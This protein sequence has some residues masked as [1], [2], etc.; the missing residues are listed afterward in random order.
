MKTITILKISFFV[1]LFCIATNSYSQEYNN[2][3]D[4]L[5]VELNKSQSDTIKNNILNEMF[6]IYIKHDWEQAISTSKNG[7]ALFEQNNPTFA[8][9]WNDKLGNLYMEKGLYSM[10]LRAYSNAF[11][12]L[13]NNNINVGSMYLNIAKIYYLQK[14]YDKSISIYKD[15]IK[16]FEK[17]EDSDTKKSQLGIA[18]AY[19]KLGIVYELKGDIEKSKEYFNKALKTRLT[20]NNA[21]AIADSYTSLGYLANVTQEYDSAIYYL[22]KGLDV[23][24]TNENYHYFSD[25]HL[26]RSKAYTKKQKFNKA[27]NDIDTALEFAQKNNKYD[28]SR[29]YFFYAKTDIAKNDYSKFIKNANISLQY[30]D[31]F[32]LVSDK[33]DIL[34]ELIK[35]SIKNNKYKSAFEY[36]TQ[37][38]ELN[39]KIVT[40]KQNQLEKGIDFE[41]QKRQI[42]ELGQTNKSL[43]G[44]N[45]LFQIIILISSLLFIILIVVLIYLRKNRKKALNAL[46]IAEIEKEKAQKAKKELDDS[47][48]IIRSQAALAEILKNLT[49][50]ERTLNVFLQNA[51]DKLLELPWLNV[52]SKGSIFLTN[53]EGNLVMVAEKDLGEV[54]ER[55]AIIKPG[56][57][58]CGKALL[59]KKMQHC[60]HIDHNHEIRFDNMVEHGHYNLPIIMNDEV[61]GVLNIYT[62]HEHKTS[63][64]EIDFLKTVADTIASV[65]N[66][67]KSQTEI[68][69]IKED[70]EEK[71]K[72]IRRYNVQLEQQGSERDSLNQMILAQKKQ[73][74]EKN[75]QVQKQRDEVEQYAKKLEAQSI[76]QEK[77]T[78]QLFA[79]KLEVEQRN[80][81]VEQYSKQLEKQAL[82]QEKLNQQLFAQKLEVEQRNIEVQ[83]YANQL[84]GQSKEQE[85]LNQQLFAQKLEVEQRNF[86]VE[87]YTKQLEDQS[88]EQE[89]LN[90]Q[91]F[92]QKLEVEQRNFEVEQ[93]SKQIEEKAE[94]QEKL[95]Q[96]LFAQKLEV[97]QR[98]FEVEQ[99]T[100][101]LEDQAKEQEKLNQK[102]FAQ[103]LEVE[104]RNMEV[105]QYAEQLE[106]QSKEQEVLNQRLFA[107]SLEVDQKSFEIN[108][109]AKEVENLKEK[110]EGTLKHLNDSINY[111]K[112]IQDSLLPLDSFMNENIPG[113]Y[114]IYYKPKE[115]IGGDFYYANKIG[116]YLILG[117]ADCT[118]HGVPG[119][120]ITMLGIT[121]LNDIVDRNLV[122][123]TGGALNFLR[124]RIKTTFRSYGDNLQNKNGLDIS[125]CAINLKTNVMQYSGAFNPLFIFRNDELIEYKATRNPIGYYP[126]EKE[127]E[128]E[129]IQLQKDD[130]I[131]LFSDGYPDQVGGPKNRKFSKRQFKDFLQEIHTFPI[132][133]QSV[134]VDKIMHK[135]IGNNTQVDDIT[136][137][138]IK[139]DNYI[140]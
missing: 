119:A 14:K 84:E 24:N 44:N 59:E 58:L 137:M 82:E 3:I 120:L 108:R 40:Q 13:N 97:E 4:S 112:Y 23:C 88:K 7:I 85:K 76:E 131:Y 62:Q 86:E 29:V 98:N 27:Y 8:I 122:E 99:Y 135:W 60:N 56:E 9:D 21:K 136:L 45:K 127:F 5:K 138:G 57:C 1:I 121:F 49:G 87:Q 133:K 66:R 132:T 18:K 22:T 11:E 70:L 16:E 92:A 19:N 47:T 26:F 89:K 109:Y 54:A 32:N 63:E 68:K 61:L 41:I 30:A 55:C 134:F 12:L 113:D 130:L 42:I 111:S 117:V 129:E 100:Q 75:K 15:A 43:L 90:Q 73:V 2:T 116:D 17:I 115:T 72:H 80:M 104:Q 78:Q 139:W 6:N 128:T 105:Q 33:I 107:Q 37:F 65:I 110:A 71:N 25:L 93:Y 118:G 123:N 125:L 106:E 74:E 114:F 124:K 34:N 94:E 103:K 64:F 126:V 31:S 36:K 46:S 52:I 38:D 91:V 53:E 10:S 95:N 96:Q 77:N 79:Q 83:E 81:E 51:L 35:Q 48:E 102:V 28:L 69:R 101:Q 67:K 140:V 20:I 39:K 50:K